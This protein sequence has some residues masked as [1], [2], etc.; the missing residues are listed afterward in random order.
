[1]LA[2]NLQT[3]LQ[4]LVHALH[5]SGG[6]VAVEGTSIHSILASVHSLPIGQHLDAAELNADDWRPGAGQ[7][8]QS[9]WLAPALAH[10]IDRGNEQVG[11]I[12]LGARTNREAYG[13]EDLDLLVVAADSVGQLLQAEARQV[14]GRAQLLSLTTEVEAREVGLQANAQ[15]LPNWNCS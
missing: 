1:M 2:A 11:T 5:A 12:G 9:A 15:D 6:F 13:A 8:E 3:A 4:G 10:R 7:I 14:Q